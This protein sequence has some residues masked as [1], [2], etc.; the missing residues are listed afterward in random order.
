MYHQEEPLQSSSVFVQYMVYK[1]AK[2]KDITVLLDGQGADEILGGYKKYSHWFLQEMIRH[3]LSKFSYEKALLATNDF[4]DQWNYKNYLAAFFP[5][6][7]AKQLRLKAQKQQSTNQFIHK[8][9]LQQN[10]NAQSL[11]KPVIKGLQDI[12]TYNTHIFGLHDLLRYADKNSMAHS[13]EVRLPFLNKELEA[14]VS[15]LPST[16]KINN[17]FTKWILRESIKNK[18][19]QEIV[20][21]KGKI[22]YEPPQ[23]EWMQ[24]KQV[25]EMIIS[26]REKLVS[27]N[28]L[29]SS[30]LDTNIQSK[31]AHDANNFDWWILCAAQ[32]L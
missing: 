26:A 12:L 18:L 11:Q 22:G 30:I 5:K 21:R 20:W 6:I 1:L 29:N 16:F 32:I 28:I 27:Q 15:S 25:Q 24:H 9:F 10:K 4:L 14:F 31:S 13:R 17:G 23:Q 2:E 19:P 7:T 8:D 3:N